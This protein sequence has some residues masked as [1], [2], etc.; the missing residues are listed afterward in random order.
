MNKRI[1]EMRDYMCVNACMHAIIINPYT[2]HDENRLI[3]NLDVHEQ[4]FQKLF[5]SAYY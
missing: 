3:Q 4:Y 1:S 5:A 2:M